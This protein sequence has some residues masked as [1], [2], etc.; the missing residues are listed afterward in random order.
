MTSTDVGRVRRAA[1]ALL[2]AILGLLGTDVAVA[3]P[4]LKVSKPAGSPAA[5]AA[6]GALTVSVKVKNPGKRK[7][8]AQTVRVVLSKDGR[9]D[10]KD[11]KLAGV[12]K[13]K[14]LA[15][16]KSATAKG[17][18][19]VPNGAAA[20]SYKLIACV[21]KTCAAGSAIA[22][23]GAATPPVNTPLPSRPSGD[24]VNLPPGPAP[25][26]NPG[27]PV[28]PP[29]PGPS[30]T[31]DPIPQDPKDGGAGAGPRRRDLGL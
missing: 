28:P 22:L 9:A 29:G 20:G 10:A 13:L 6:G 18:L 8:K 4:A 17:K 31:P 14:A 11:I 7:A 2:A 1:V 23:K 25:V 12:L 5:V 27:D 24:T 15:G 19:T 3:A 26:P 30:P 16:R 21:G